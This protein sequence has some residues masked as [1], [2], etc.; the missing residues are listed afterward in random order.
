MA[1]LNVLRNAIES[2]PT[3]STVRVDLK[4][5]D[6]EVCVTIDDEGEGLPP[7]DASQLFKPFHTTRATGSGLG[8][9]IL[10]RIMKAHGG[11]VHV[12]NLPTRGARFELVFA[13]RSSE[14]GAA[15]KS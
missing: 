4:A 11:R 3:G 15:A 13:Y 14:P 8:L 10:E 9:A 6:G 12:E 5:S 2:S 1:L 7:G